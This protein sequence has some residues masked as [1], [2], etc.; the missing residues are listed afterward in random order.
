M[1]QSKLHLEVLSVLSDNLEQP[2]PDL[3]AT[4]EVL[5]RMKVETGQLHQIL[6]VMN[7]K[8]LI[9]TDYDLQF[10]L[11]TPKGLSFLRHRKVC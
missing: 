1:S 9:Q 6:K 7:G 3:V 11:I 2:H 4:S 5:D 10:S 8:G